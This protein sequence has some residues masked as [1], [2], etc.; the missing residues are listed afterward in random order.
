M[1]RRKQPLNQT[2]LDVTTYGTAPP[3]NDHERT[4]AYITEKEHEAAE[5]NKRR[6]NCGRGD[7][8]P[9]KKHLPDCLWLMP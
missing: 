6:C 1:A 8:P 5:R 2:T 4:Q 7:G 9:L 3:R